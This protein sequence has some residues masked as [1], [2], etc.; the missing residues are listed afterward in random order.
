MDALGRI[1]AESFKKAEKMPL[2]VV[3]DNVRSMHNVGSVFRSS[4]AFL[5]EAI[6]LCGFTPCPPHRDIHKTALGSTDTVTWKYV[7]ET[8]NAINQLKDDGYTIVSVEQV[9]NSITLPEV[10]WDGQSKMAIV[11]GNEVD[12][13]DQDI[14]N[15]SSYCIEIPQMGTK[16]SLNISVAT[17]IV[18]YKMAEFYISSK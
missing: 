7:D 9:T 14:I 1:D 4:D 17:G 15:E 3:L 18:L 10:K 2:V 6:Y 13:V 5:V 12:G 16:H 11:M 8:I